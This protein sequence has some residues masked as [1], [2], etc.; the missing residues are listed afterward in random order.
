MTEANYI[1]ISQA[2]RGALPFM[3]LMKEITF[4]IELEDDVSKVKSSIFE[5]LAIEHEGNQ[6]TIALA[7]AL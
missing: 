7:V 4:V 2:I 5:K 3:S 1:A 6:V